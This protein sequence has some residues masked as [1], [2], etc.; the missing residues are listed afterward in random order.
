MIRR[1]GLR[2]LLSAI[3]REIRAVA[4]GKR[5]PGQ[6]RIYLA[7]QGRK[8]L[9]GLL[10]ACVAAALAQAGSAFGEPGLVTA[11]AG[12]GVL[13]G[14]LVSAGLV[15]AD[16][17]TAPPEDGRL[18]RLLRDH[19]A[20]VAALL[21]GAAALL[22]ACDADVAGLLAQAHM[23]CGQAQGLLVALGAVL[24]QLGLQAEARMAAP[25]NTEDRR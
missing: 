4:E 19:S 16:W 24:A 18:T 15:D 20:D 23:T 3:G 12:V 17:R 11:G 7:L 22:Q 13:A 25:P 14:V 1:L 6:Q 2:L 10:L 5:G 8:R 21:A 9:I